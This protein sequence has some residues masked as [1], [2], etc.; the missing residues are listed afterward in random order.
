MVPR[1]VRWLNRA[2]PTATSTTLTAAYLEPL[3]RE[4]AAI[5]LGERN[6]L[7]LSDTPADEIRQLPR[8]EWL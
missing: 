6:Q 2:S 3:V 1:L 8:G 7:K 5:S 4:R